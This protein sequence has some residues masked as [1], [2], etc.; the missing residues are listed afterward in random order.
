MSPRFV[1]IGLLVLALLVGVGVVLL[2]RKR[3]TAAWGAFGAVAGMVACLSVSEFVAVFAIS[4]GGY[5]SFAF[6][7]EHTFY[8]LLKYDDQIR[9]QLVADLLNGALGVAGAA[10]GTAVA[11]GIS[12][13]IR[14]RQAPG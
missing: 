9:I 4:G 3:R 10:A 6:Y 13:L 2:W 7:W 5:V 8:P 11:V 1:E 12:W 14:K